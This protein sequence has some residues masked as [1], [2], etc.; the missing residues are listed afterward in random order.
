MSSVWLEGFHQA[1]AAPGVDSKIFDR[2]PPCDSLIPLKP[3]ERARLRTQC[4]DGNTVKHDVQ[5]TVFVPMCQMF[6]QLSICLDLLQLHCVVKKD[7]NEKKS[8]SKAITFKE[9]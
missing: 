7:E 3:Q 4:T 1:L 9:M 8:Y 2:S 5:I 6:S